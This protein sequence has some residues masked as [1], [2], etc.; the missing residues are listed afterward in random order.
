MLT[1]A[2]SLRIGF[3]LGGGC[4][5]ACTFDPAGAGAG[6]GAGGGGGARIGAALSRFDAG[7]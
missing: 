2:V 7:F 1:G 6:A 5:F 4:G 3:A